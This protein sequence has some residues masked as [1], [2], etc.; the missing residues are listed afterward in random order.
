V[1]G[2]DLT[3]LHCIFLN[4]WHQLNER[5]ETAT[6]YVRAG[7]SF[8]VWPISSLSR[9]ELLRVSPSVSRSLWK[10]AVNQIR[11]IQSN[12][13]HH[14]QTVLC[15]SLSN[16]PLSYCLASRIISLSVRLIFISVL[17]SANG[18]SVVTEII[19]PSKHNK[20]QRFLDLSKSSVA[21]FLGLFFVNFH[22][23]EK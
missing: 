6:S 12:R 16:F 20:Y 23:V 11:S 15:L 22:G 2:T 13:S 7:L 21:F 4:F 5:N 19:I 9:N 3:P 8:E 18:H 10:G 14:M 1:K 17:I